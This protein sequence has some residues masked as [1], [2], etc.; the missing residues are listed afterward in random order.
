VANEG[1]WPVKGTRLSRETLLDG[2]VHELA[3]ASP[4]DVRIM[5]D[6]ER[7]ASLEATLAR[8]P[9]CGDPW[10]FGY[11]SLIWNPAF[12]YVERRIGRVYGFHRRFCLWTMMGR[13][14]PERP[15][16][17]LGLEAGGSCGGVVY[18][19]AKAQARTELDLVWRREMLTSAYR[20]VWVRVH[21]PDGVEPAVTFAINAEHDRYTGRLTEARICEAIATAEGYLGRCS[22]YLVETVRHLAELGIHDRRLEAIA[23][24]VHALADGSHS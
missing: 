19:V 23:R 22:E 11:G 10:V 4:A 3:R 5:S 16:L 20:A 24:D 1:Q 15:G 2:T 13:G 9:D 8:A 6:D 7:R 14:S 12:H 17:V 21:T 18:R